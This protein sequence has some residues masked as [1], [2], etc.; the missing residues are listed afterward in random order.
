MRLLVYELPKTKEECPFF[1]S[2]YYINDS[3][4]MRN[5]CRITKEVCD[6]QIKQKWPICCS[7]LDEVRK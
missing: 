4:Y 5:Y 1:V 7:G 6:L 3:T 2:R